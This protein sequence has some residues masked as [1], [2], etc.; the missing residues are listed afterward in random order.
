MNRTLH[1][2]EALRRIQR[3]P[4]AQQRRLGDVVSYVVTQ[5]DEAYDFLVAEGLLW[6]SEW[7][8]DEGK[9]HRLLMFDHEVDAAY[10]EWAIDHNRKGQP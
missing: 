5:P 9:N 3:L 4:V 6:W 1:V 2:N 10:T 8:D 7:T